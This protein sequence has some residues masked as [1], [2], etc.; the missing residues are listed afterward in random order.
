M[1]RHG[2]AVGPALA[3]VLA[4]ALG[5]LLAAPAGPASAAPAGERTVTLANQDA[6]GNPTMRFDTDGNAIDAHDGQI[7]RFGDLYYL[8][9]TSYACGYRWNTVGAPFCGFVSY[10]SPDLVHWTPQG[11]LFDASTPTW[12]ERCDGGTYGCYRPHV[13][14]NAST[15]KYVLWINTYDVG[16][17]YRVFTSDRPDGDF[18]EAPVPDLAA[19]EGAPRATNYG[20]HSVFVDHDGSAYLVF[21]DWIKGG[22]LIVEK[23]DPT[24]TTGSGQWSRVGLRS[25]EAPTIFERGGTYYLTYSDPNRGY[26]TTGTG[27]VTASSPLGPWQGAGTQQG[28]WTV[29]DGALTIVGG[30]AGVSRAG[31]DWTDYTFHADITLL[32]A[33]KGGYAQ[34]GLV[35]RSSEAGSYQWLLGNFAYPGQESGNLTKLIPGKAAS[36]VPVSV[37]IVTG[38]TYAVDITVHGSTIETRI[39]GTLV[40][41]TTDSTL[42][43]GKVGFR[44]SDPDGEGVTVSGVTVTSAGGETLMSDDFS[45]GLAQWDRPVVG[46]NLTTTSCGGQPADVL[47]LTTSSGTVYLYQSDVWMNGAAN[48]ALAKQYWAPLEF[49]DD[50]GL[51]PIVCEPSVDVTIPVG[52]A[53]AASAPPAVSTGDVDFQTYSDI[54]GNLA[55]AQ[56]FTVPQGRLTAV[57]YSSFQTGLP[58]AGL[59]LTLRRVAVDG[60]VGDVVT[61][62]TVP[63]SEIS[64]SPSWQTLTLPDGGLEVAAGERFLL[65]VAS[66]TTTGGYGM[67]YRD[68]SPYAGGQALISHDAGG[69]WTPE[70]GRTLRLA[71]DMVTV[72]GAPTG[73]S[74]TAAGTEVTV[75]WSAP[76]QDGG[77]VVEGYRVYRAGTAAPVATVDADSTGARLTGLMP[78][79]TLQLTVTATNA[80]GESAPSAPVTVT[81]PRGDE[82]RPPVTS[83]VTVV[84]S[85]SSV[86]AGARLP[87]TVRVAAPG[88]AGPLSG[89]V[90]VLEDGR[91]VAAGAVTASGAVTLTLPAHGTAGGRTLT[92]AYTGNAVA[93]A[94]VSRPVRLT[95]AKAQAK[96]TLKIA[97]K[98]A[99]KAH[100]GAK[101]KAKIRVR[102]PSGVSARGKV[103][104]RDKKGGTKVKVTVPASGKK[105]VK[106][107]LAAKAGKHKIVAKYRGSKDVAKAKSTTKVTVRR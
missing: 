75:T 18:V 48:E 72:P 77:S 51:L 84:P 87:V 76:E 36:R 40:D 98:A 79:E 24:Y 58:D 54:H 3:A 67:M 105:T 16:V 74:A 10:S 61:T 63:V 95:V 93:K 17:G 104:L 13:V 73:V 45:D 19:P 29:A 4:L 9:G 100:A 46:T 66:T 2:K 56:T 81:V 86:R 12:Q 97:K 14:F 103:V 57:R 11:P 34:V 20:D 44:E 59:T 33:T 92:A 94:A 90:T 96:I 85:S 64:W 28:P 5:A 21:T 23:L 65:G 50:G 38:Q 53:V 25:T 41:T 49:D 91:K 32:E 8:Y 106:V 35:F 42:T 107:R 83:T 70:V 31:A 27:Y 62:R 102:V 71:A 69:T 99:K 47:P 43:A 88:A 80:I 15:H 101:V 60:T 82:S 22:D 78:G 39:D 89:T 7:Q 68:T 30:G 52:T 1:K 26:A 6:A 55:R 37:P